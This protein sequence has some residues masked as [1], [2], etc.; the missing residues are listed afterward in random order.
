MGDRRYLRAMAF[1]LGGSIAEKE[2]QIRELV[3]AADDNLR[4]ALTPLMQELAA[5]RLERDQL[6]P[7]QPAPQPVAGDTRTR[8]HLHHTN[9]RL[10]LVRDVATQTQP[11]Q[12]D[13]SDESMSA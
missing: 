4:L 8:M 12:S 11:E 1:E 2:A 13:D 7:P 10:V 9:A 3:A 5:L 6:F